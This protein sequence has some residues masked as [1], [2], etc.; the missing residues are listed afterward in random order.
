MKMRIID[1]ENGHIQKLRTFVIVCM[2][3]FPS[4]H[5]VT[6]SYRLK[7]RLSGQI[8][9]HVVSLLFLKAD[10]S[11]I[12]SLLYDYLIVCFCQMLITLS[13][14]FIVLLQ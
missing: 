2:F 12:I 3:V 5:M 1:Y 11:S 13:Y 14:D 4:V 9:E 10:S 8:T 7:T 6:F